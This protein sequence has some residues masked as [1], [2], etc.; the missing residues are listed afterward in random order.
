MINDF[1]WLFLCSFHLYFT[2]SKAGSKFEGK[3]TDG[4]KAGVAKVSVNDKKRKD[5]EEEEDEEEDEEDD[6]DDEDDD[7]MG[8]LPKKVLK[9]VVAI[10]KI[11]SSVED[12]DLEYKKERIAL[13]QKYLALKQ[14]LFDARDKII[15]GEVEAPEEEAAPEAASEAVEDEDE[16]DV[17]GIPGF[18]LQCLGAHHVTGELIAEEDVPAL[19]ALTSITC[20]YDESFSSFTLKFTF[21]ENE[22]FTNTVLTKTYGVSPDLLDEK[23]PALTSNEGT[24]IDWKPTK[25]LTVTEIKKKQ[26]AKSGRNKGQVRTV[27]TTVP[28]ASFFHFFST[29]TGEEDEE[30]EGKDEDDEEGHQ[31]IKL[32]MEED[33]DVGHTIRTA[34]IPEAVL[35][36]TG[37]AVDDE[38]DE[39]EDDEG[40][41]GESD[42]EDE[43]ES[44][45][46]EKPA[47]KKK[48]GKVVATEGGF[49]S[50]GAPAAGG[51]Q[52]E[53][54][55]N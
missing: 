25:N 13:E 12:I 9:R 8:N 53:C 39:D 10:R 23:A 5:E 49:A 46:D 38:Y 28:K 16:E 35:W 55:Q 34:I 6:E 11:H 48:K 30:D 54:K 50:A 17:D 42:E 20:S 14:P 22:Y 52:P 32:T 19:E 7:G 24:A 51:E 37:E 29:P 15:S 18:W 45:E 36:Y 44:D 31:R 1:Q 26:K 27:S 41:Y 43:E 40:L 21:A 3:G 4:I 2:M 47:D 33:Y